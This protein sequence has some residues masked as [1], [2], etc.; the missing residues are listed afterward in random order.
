MARILIIDE[1]SDLIAHLSQRV[2]RRGHVVFSASDGAAGLASARAASPDIV[3]VGTRLAGL[4]GLTIA[5][6]I[7]TD[8][9]IRKSRIIALLASGSDEDRKNALSSGC[10]DTHVKPIDF[11]RLM[12]QIDALIEPAP[13]AASPD[14]ETSSEVEGEGEAVQA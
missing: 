6:A 9:N 12:Q 7:K 2:E 1:N 14:E 3:L 4:D 5:H 13:P 10:D 11:V 8:P